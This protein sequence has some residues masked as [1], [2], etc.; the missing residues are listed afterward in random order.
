VLTHCHYDHAGAASAW[1]RAGATVYVSE[2][3]AEQN[4]SQGSLAPYMN[5]TYEPYR[6]PVLVREGDVIPFGSSAF[7]VLVT[8]GHTRGSICLRMGNV[9]VTGDTLFR[10]S[11]GR[12][13]L[14]TGSLQEMRASIKRL[15][16]L[17]GNPSVY[18]G[19]NAFTTL[20]EERAENPLG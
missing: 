9:L 1:E 13:D 11:Y 15:L 17:E 10:R 16:S 8:P 6:A 2:I 20:D 18:P 5:R 7:T 14:P 12:I 3:D 19:H 4:S